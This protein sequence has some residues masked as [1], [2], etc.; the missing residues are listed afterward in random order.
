MASKIKNILV[1]HGLKDNNDRSESSIKYNHLM[2]FKDN[3]IIYCIIHLQGYESE[4]VQVYKISKDKVDK[5]VK[6]FVGGC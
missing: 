2:Y 3:N 5:M 6:Y 4:S 1:Q